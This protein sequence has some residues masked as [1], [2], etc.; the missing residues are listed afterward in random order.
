MARRHRRFGAVAKHGS[1]GPGRGSRFFTVDVQVSRDIGAA[2]IVQYYSQ[3]CV[4]KRGAGRLRSRY[5]PRMERR[6]G[7][8]AGRTPTMAGKAA[9]RSLVSKLK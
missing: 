3:A 4:T 8:G 9:L 5:G 2:T 7:S 6:C 1:S